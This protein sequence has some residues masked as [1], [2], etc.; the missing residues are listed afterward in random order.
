VFRAS[1]R[2]LRHVVQITVP[3]DD[4]GRFDLRRQ[5]AAASAFTATESAQRESVAALDAVLEPQLS[6]AAFA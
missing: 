2:N 6:I 4:Q 1:L 5:L 3:V